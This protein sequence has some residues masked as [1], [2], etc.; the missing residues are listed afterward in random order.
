M[1][2]EGTTG[3]QSIDLMGRK[4]SLGN[5]EAL[6][7]LHAEIEATLALVNSEL[8]QDCA[9]SLERHLA[10]NADVL[11]RSRTVARGEFELYLADATLYMELL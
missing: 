7:L 1:I 4:L 10:L 11:N 3:I 5:G 8:L 6:R 9:A 2:N